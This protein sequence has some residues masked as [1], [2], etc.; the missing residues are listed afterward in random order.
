[1]RNIFTLCFLLFAPFAFSQNEL[2]FVEA[3][4]FAEK[5]GWVV[6]QQFMDIMGSPIL[7]AH[8][9][10]VPV[11]DATTEVIFPRAGEYQVFVRTRNWAS[12]WT[13]DPAHA[14]GKFQLSV[15]GKKLDT[16]F[17]TVSNPWHWQPGGTVTVS[18]TKAK[19][20][21]HDLTGFNGRLDAIIFTSDRNYT[22]PED[23]KEIDTIRRRS[24]GLPADPL[25]APAAK[26]G[27]FD[28]VVVGGGIA[29]MCSAVSAARLGCKVALIQDR[30]VLGG[31]NSSEVRVHLQ[32]RIGYPPYPNLGNLVHELD[33]QREGN[34][35][36]ADNYNDERKHGVVEAE[37]NITL[38]LSTRMI[39]VETVKNTDVP[40]R[41][42]RWSAKISKPAWKQNLKA[43]S[44]PTALVTLTLVIL[45]VRNGGWG[46]RDATKQEKNLPRKSTTR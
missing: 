27:P 21:L 18:N 24:L 22:P 28:F 29:G 23:I 34:A 8:G 17:G 19:L 36:P 20:A 37:K 5:G 43:N 10:G 41:S 42:N 15:N 1:M 7:M 38:Y 30:P 9:M 11:A 40:S 45:P 14:P 32:G 16:V 3:E 39:A 25:A 6:D 2:V 44:L 35:H 46:E 12:P 33:P 26:E 13:T 31:N 4:A